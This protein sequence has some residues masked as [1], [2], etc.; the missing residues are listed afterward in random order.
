MIE[1]KKILQ[2]SNRKF[3]QKEL[4]HVKQKSQK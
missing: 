2:Q 4:A 3:I 1:D